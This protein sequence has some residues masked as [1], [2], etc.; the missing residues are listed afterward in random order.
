MI[1]IFHLAELK[2]MGGVFENQG[3]I[4]HIESCKSHVLT[5]TDQGKISIWRTKDWTN[6]HS[7]KGHRKAI[8]GLALHPSS[9]MLIS[10]GRDRKLYLWNLVKAR[11]SFKTRLDIVLE[12]I[13]WSPCGNF[14]IGKNY[15]EVRIFNA[16]CNFKD[17]FV[18]FMHS[19][20]IVSIGFLGCSECFF[21]GDFTG[22]IVLSRIG[23]GSISFKA[24]D[25][26]L[27]KAVFIQQ[28]LRK[29][30]VTVSTMGEVRVWN[31]TSI[32]KALGD[33][34][35]NGFFKV[36][37]VQDLMLMEVDLKCRCSTVAACLVDGS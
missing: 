8:T 4:E 18:R 5:G 31:V 32:F 27:C 34:V 17:E 13:Q 33:T 29:I 1:R 28:E 20:Q 11:P 7:F 12:E 35:K 15:R 19:V 16:E 37:N 14:F 9:R 25:G 21:I 30:I 23:R 2:E 26:R 6:L 36:D 10:T 3:S 24:H 22:E